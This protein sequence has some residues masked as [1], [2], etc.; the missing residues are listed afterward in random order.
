MQHALEIQAE[1]LDRWKK[2]LN[3]ETYQALCDKTVECNEAGYDSPYSVF[4]GDRI[5]SWIQNYSI[6]LGK[7]G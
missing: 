4:R 5:T 1:C 6:M 3:E 7:D 2:V